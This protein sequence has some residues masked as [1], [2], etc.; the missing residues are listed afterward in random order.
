MHRKTHLYH[1]VPSSYGVG[2]SNA[3]ARAVC[4]T[5][6]KRYEAGKCHQAS[7]SSDDSGG[8]GVNSEFINV[9]SFKSRYSTLRQ[10]AVRREILYKC[11]LE[12]SLVEM[13]SLKRPVR[14]ETKMGIP[15]IHLALRY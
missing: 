13:G 3:S 6:K 9:T 14:A 4:T 5:V 2:I 15:S 10:I 12:R 11:E 8:R 1:T 7:L